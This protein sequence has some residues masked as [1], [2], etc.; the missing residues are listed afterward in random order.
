M[1]KYRE[2]PIEF[3]EKER[4]HAHTNNYQEIYEECMHTLDGIESLELND[5]LSK[6]LNILHDLVVMYDV[7]KDLYDEYV[8]NKKGDTLSEGAKQLANSLVQ[9]NDSI[10]LCIE[11]DIMYGK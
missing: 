4:P 1:S 7:I 2:L 9:I 6:R 3:F 11:I 8:I 10:K 5:Y